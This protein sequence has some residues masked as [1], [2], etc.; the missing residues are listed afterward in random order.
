MKTQYF[1]TLTVLTLALAGCGS[2]GG[3][4]EE[5]ANP[6]NPGTPDQPSNPA[7]PTSALQGL[8]QSA[9]GA[10]PAMSAIGMPDGQLWSVVTGPEAVHVLQANLTGQTSSYAGKGTIYLLGSDAVTSGNVTASVVEKSTLTGAVTQD[11]GS[12]TPFSLAYQARYD[13]PATLAAFAGGWRDVQGPGAQKWN[14]DSNGALTGTRTTGCTYAGQLSERAE[15]KA[16][17]DVTM[18]ENCAG[19]R[20]RLQGIATLNTSDGISM[21]VI[22]EDR[23]AAVALNLSR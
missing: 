12:S 2:G 13:T 10:S 5:A 6:A 14:I 4:N 8:W 11:D 23:T 17:I 21:V 20:V 3:G 16:V 1:L 18:T 9:A 15:R 19:T 7:L 22:T